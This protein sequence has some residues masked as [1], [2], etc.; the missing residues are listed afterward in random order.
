[1]KLAPS[2]LATGAKLCHY[3]VLSNNGCRMPLNYPNAVRCEEFTP[4]L[5]FNPP[6]VGLEGAFSTFRSSAIWYDRARVIF[7][8]HKRLAL[9][10]PS[11]GTTIAIATMTGAYR[12]PF[13]ELMDEHAKTN[14]LTLAAG[15]SD[16]S[17]PAWL[18]KQIRNR[19]GVRYVKSPEQIGTVIYLHVTPGS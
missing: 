1:M 13:K 2:A 4:T 19:M 14:H 16:E 9:V 5:G 3:C 18:T 15:V 17:A 6:L 12:G 10:N 11:D 8:S 7:N